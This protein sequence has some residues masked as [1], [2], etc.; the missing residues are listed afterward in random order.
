[1]SITVAELFR[2]AGAAKPLELPGYNVGAVVHIEE[3]LNDDRRYDLQMALRRLPGVR[4]AKFAANQ[5]H[6]LLVSYDRRITSS[7]NIVDHVRNRD[8]NAQLVGPL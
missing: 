4:K 2:N 7:S 1:M 5:H 3:D 8:L 6:L